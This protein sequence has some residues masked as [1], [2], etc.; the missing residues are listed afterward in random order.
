MNKKKINFVLAIGIILTAFFVTIAIVSVFYTP[1]DPYDMS[2]KEK[3]LKP[4]GKHLMGTDNFGR[5]IFSRVMVAVKNS[6]VISGSA[7]LISFIIGTFVGSITGY[8]GGIID[9]ILMRINDALASIPSILTAMV[10][11][12]LMD[13][14]QKTLIIALIVAFIPS[15]AR[16]SRSQVIALKNRDFVKSAKLSGAS[17]FRIIFKH[18]LPNGKSALVT[19]LSVGFNNA[20]LAEASLSFLGLG[21]QPPDPSIGSL[22]SEAQMYVATAPYYVVF[23]TIVMVLMVVGVVMI[24]E[25]YGKN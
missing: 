10:F 5:D 20:I 16:V 21:I 12:A 19:G 14:S 11:V 1:C 9:E 22:L 25:G 2:F 6:L 17:N 8:Y 7:I 15:F 24:G 4:S 13:K 3:F 18:I 23:P